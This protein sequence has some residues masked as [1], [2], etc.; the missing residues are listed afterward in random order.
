MLLLGRPQFRSNLANANLEVL[1]HQRGSRIPFAN[2]FYAQSY[3]RRDWKD[4]VKNERMESVRCKSGFEDKLVDL[5]T[6]T[7]ATST[8][9]KIFKL[10][11]REIE[12]LHDQLWSVE[13]TWSVLNH[14]V[15]DARSLREPF[16]RYGIC[17]NRVSNKLSNISIH[18]PHSQ[19]GKTVQLTLVFSSHASIA[20]LSTVSQS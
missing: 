4:T 15:L 14:A 6:I 12:T 2:M 5:Y 19:I 18:T 8:Y 10:Q 13:A 16:E 11:F 20:K 17:S 7:Y 9:L 1:L 3:F